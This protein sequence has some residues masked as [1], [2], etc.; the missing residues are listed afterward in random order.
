MKPDDW[1][2]ALRNLLKG[3]IVAREPLARHTSY[4]VGGPAD[5]YVEPATKGDLQ[6]LVRWAREENIPLFVLGKGTNLLVS[7]SGV[8][9]LVVNVQR[10]CKEWDVGGTRVSVGAGWLLT[11]MLE[12]LAAVGLSGYEALYG[13]PGTVGGALFMNAGAF[14]TEIADR[15]LRVEL[16]NKEGEIFFR[17]KSQLEFGYRR[18]IVNRKW[19]ILSA[20][21]SLEKGSPEKIR[22]KMQ[23]IWQR[24]RAKQPVTRAS[25][26][27][28]FKRPKGY[29]AG[30]LV[31]GAGL[32]GFRHGHALISRKH[33]NFIV[34]AG[35]ASATEIRELMEIVRERVKQK[36]GVELELENELIG[37]PC[38]N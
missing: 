35:G 3:K 5:V 38:E 33:A 15:L 32:K 4:R 10:C 34:N 23:E 17:E 27:S 6:H 14:G 16:M 12:K 19:V 13:I 2:N 24:R 8:R 21:F 29:Y 28:V 7:D 31:Q 1:A 36:Y 30:A 22:E 26:G 11:K 25:A 37:W 18:G 20:V 9:G